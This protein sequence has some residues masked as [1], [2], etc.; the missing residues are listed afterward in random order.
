MARHKKGDDIHGWVVLDKPYELGSTQAVSK[1]RWLFNA[2]KAGHAGTLD[3]L[4]T[5][6]LPIALGDATKTVPYVQDG[7]KTYRFTVAWGTATSTDDLEG[8]VIA[9]SDNRPTTDEILSTLSH[10][11]G[12][13]SQVPPAY[14]AIK[15]DGERA[16]TLA[17]RG[18]TVEMQ[19]RTVFIESLSLVGAPDSDHA[20]FEVVCGKG[21][22]VRSLARDLAHALETEVHVTD[23]R[24]VAVGPFTE[25][26]MISLDSLEEMRHRSGADAGI[27]L[28]EGLHSVL[29]P[30]ETA[31]DDIPALALSEGDAALIHNGQ[32]VLLR[33]SN[34]P[35]S[36]DEAYATASGSLVALGFVEAG[37]FVPKRVF[38]SAP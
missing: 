31:L 8:E 36:L 34:A 23:L 26:Q 2:K 9:T 37:R 33:G 30:I 18:E 20:I 24:R 14:S 25:T 19:A 22:Y 21:T 28:K 29:F 7:L 5:G 6:M 38:K 12:D 17:R 27:S 35:L 10:F 15:I 1:V 16:Y 11:E 13:I 32:S 3:P 4:A